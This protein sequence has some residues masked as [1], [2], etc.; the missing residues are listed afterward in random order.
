MTVSKGYQAFVLDQLHVLGMVTARP[1]FGGVG[2][3]H[4]GVFF[5]LIYDDTVFL[6]VDDS[7]RPDFERAG[8]KPFQPYGEESYSM[9]YYELPADVL[10]DRSALHTWADKAVAVARRSATAKRKNRG[11]R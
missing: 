2:L 4:A 11:K 7:N 3:Y 6:K 9:T 10:E 1:M 5:G 8:S